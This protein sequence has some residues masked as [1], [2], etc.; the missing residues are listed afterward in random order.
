MNSNFYTDLALEIAESIS[1]GTDAIEGLQVDAEEKGNIRITT[2]RITNETGAGA[3]GKPLGNYITI[4]SPDI[5]T[6]DI[7]AHEEIMSVLVDKIAL[8]RNGLKIGASDTVLVIGLGN[9]NVTPDALGPMVVSKTLVTRHIMQDL[10]KE[11]RSTLRPLAAIA[12]GVMGM[13]G[14]ETAEAVKG[15]VDHVKPALVIAVDALA[16]RNIGRINQTIQLTDTGISP[17][18]GVGNRRMA[19]NS[20]TM[21]TPVL[22]IGVPTVVDAAT[23]VNDTLDLFLSEMAEDAPEFLKDGTKFFEMLNNLEDCDKYA[24]IRNTITPYVGNMFVTPKEVGEVVRWLS[25]IIANGIN[26][27]MHK[28]ITKDD[29]NR[30]MY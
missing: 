26:M 25:N 27:S 11:L 30:F 1:G 13:T 23:L 20:E 4:E 7:E 12:P 9:H 5:Q 3:M 24:I 2:V 18:A 19:L 29:I 6:N 22:A 8:L 21:G 10:P 15:L 17:G 16:A 28:G 14:I